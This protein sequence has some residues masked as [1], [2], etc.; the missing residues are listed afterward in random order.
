MEPQEY[1]LLD[2]TEEGMWWFAAAHAVLLGAL[3]RLPGPAGSALLDAGCGTG[4]LLKRLAASVPGR[5]RAG[6]DYAPDAISRA[7][8]KTDALLAVASIHALPFATGS[9][10][11]VFSVDVLCHRAVDEARAL[12]ELHRVL[13][14]GGTLLINMPAYQWLHS[15]HD[16]RVHNRRRYTRAE[17][18]A[19][20][21]AAGFEAIEARYWN[22]LLFPVMVLQRKVL[23][24]GGEDEPASDVARFPPLLDAMFRAVLAAER[25]LMRAGLRFPF[26]GSILAVARKPGP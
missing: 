17:V 15:A 13:A 22:S 20:V 10:G 1:A 9:F 21:A 4:G 18:R 7:R 3:A 25:G 23:A 14:P 16:R 6:I 8:A 19:M 5:P 24:R 26:G 2:A 11:A 12:A